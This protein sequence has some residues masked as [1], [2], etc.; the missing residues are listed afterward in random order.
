MTSLR[1]DSA[2]ER[3]LMAAQAASPSAVLVGGTGLALLVGHRRSLDL[4]VFCPAS[5]PLAPVVR[6]VEAEAERM[7]AELEHVR[8]TPGFHR[9]AVSC[10]GQLVRF[11]VAHE[12]ADRLAPPV[13]VSG[14]RVASL[15][16]QRANKLVAL[17]G[18]SELRDL[19]DLLFIERA[20]FP[21]AEGFD[22]AIAKDGGMDPAWFAWAVGQIRMRTLDGMVAPLTQEEVIVFR[23][24]LQR[25]ALD[26]VGKQ[27]V[28]Q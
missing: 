12:T 25:A 14:V 20:G 16:D 17:L 15:R 6:A 4:D 23:D 26:R 8:T 10:G 3:L 22:D 9:L 28:G 21:A 18:R 7:S 24:A 2:A 27:P 1:L 11:D 5:E 13:V 19:V